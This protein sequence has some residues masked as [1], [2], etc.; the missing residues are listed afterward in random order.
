MN[1]EQRCMAF[2][3]MQPEGPVLIF[4]PAALSLAYMEQPYGIRDALLGGK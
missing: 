4:Q 3:Q 1:D 2:F